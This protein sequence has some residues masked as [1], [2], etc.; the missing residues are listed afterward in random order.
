MAFC[1]VFSISKFFFKRIPSINYRKKFH[2][3]AVLTFLCVNSQL[4]Q[5][6]RPKKQLIYFKNKLFVRKTHYL[7]PL[8]YSIDEG[9]KPLFSTETLQGLYEYQGTLID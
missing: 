9:L 4:L 7:Q 3:S 5:I 8:P 2:T 6:N 1:R